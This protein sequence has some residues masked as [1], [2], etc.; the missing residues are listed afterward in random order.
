MKDL[1]SLGLYYALDMLV[2]AKLKN[3][4]GRDLKKDCRVCKLFATC[5]RVAVAISMLQPEVLALTTLISEKGT[6]K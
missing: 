2:Q 4:G 1:T 3:C 5:N 6:K